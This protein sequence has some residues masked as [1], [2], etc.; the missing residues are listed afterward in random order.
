MSISYHQPLSLTDVPQVPE[1][2]ATH[3]VQAP[4]S[5]QVDNRLPVASTSFLELKLLPS[6]TQALSQH[7]H[8][9]TS[10]AVWSPVCQREVGP[11]GGRPLSDTRQLCMTPLLVSSFTEITRLDELFAPL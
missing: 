2:S 7:P 8:P 9:T 1:H 11:G 5:T 10:S 3:Q 6:Q 4:A